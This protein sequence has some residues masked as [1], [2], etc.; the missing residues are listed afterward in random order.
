VASPYNSISSSSIERKIIKKEGGN[1]KKKGNNARTGKIIER[2][3]G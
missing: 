3:M 1:R 2:G